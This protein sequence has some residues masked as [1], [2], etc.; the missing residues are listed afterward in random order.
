MV[1]NVYGS[2]SQVYALLQAQRQAQ[3]SRADSDGSQALSLEEF[4]AAAGNAS[5]NTS[6]IQSLF[7]SIDSD[8]DGSLTQTELEAS[9]KKA[10]ESRF[11]QNS[12]SGTLVQG[13]DFAQQLISKADSDS[14][15]TLSLAEFD[16][17][18]PKDAPEGGPS[19]EDIFAELDSD[20]DGELTSTEL[21]A[22]QPRGGPGGPHAAG[23]P[24]PGGGNEDESDYDSALDTNGDGV[25]SMTE[26]LAA[27]S[28]SDTDAVDALMKLFDSDSDGSV[29]AEELSKGVKT[30]QNQ[31]MSYLLQQ[32]EAA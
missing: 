26:R 19:S 6:D 8:N 5:T 28:G 23:G 11:S 13:Q 3:F 1:S 2:S 22:G 29:D 20:G 30:L 25:V 9:A 7:K 24:P 32:Q 16:A 21:A 14:N 4:T 12:S 15:G 31:M 18:K 27:N 17:A 10:F